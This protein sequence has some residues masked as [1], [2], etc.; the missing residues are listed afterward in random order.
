[1]QIMNTKLQQAEDKLKSIVEN[2]SP[3]TTTRNVRRVKE[4][5]L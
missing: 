4:I 5:K 3:K 2:N 1:M